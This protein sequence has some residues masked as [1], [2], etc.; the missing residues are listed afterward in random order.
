MALMENDTRRC[1]ITQ[2]VAIRYD[3]MHKCNVRFNVLQHGRQFVN[4]CLLLL[5]RLRA[6]PIQ[7]DNDRSEIADTGTCADD[8]KRARRFG[9]VDR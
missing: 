5:Q 3:T 7:Q 4:E 8:L 1:D 2:N 9:N 6:S